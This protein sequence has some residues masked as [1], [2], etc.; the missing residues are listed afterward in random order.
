[1]TDNTAH[2]LG[3]FEANRYA[4]LAT[5][6]T[7]GRPWATPVWFAPDGLDRL[8]WVSWPGSR[9]SQLIEQR[10]DVALTVFDSTVASSDAA[11]FYATGK[12]KL[13]P[14]ADLDG[15]LRIVN[16]RSLDQG[17]GEFTREQVTGEARLRLYCAEL[18]VA[19]V[20]DQDADVDQRASVPR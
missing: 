18:T 6:D 5:S 20:L 9:H 8:Y 1:M 7:E 10:P 17:L 16:R 13:V 11:G 4:V 19:W 14:D 2:A 3:L 15:A 12:A